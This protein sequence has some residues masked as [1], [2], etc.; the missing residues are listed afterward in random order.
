M[1]INFEGIDGAGK[2]TQAKLLEKYLRSNGYEVTRMGPFTSNYGRDVRKIFMK[3][4]NISINSQLLLLGSAM[5][6]LAI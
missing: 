5:S 2:S 1:I 6:E 4:S 3:H